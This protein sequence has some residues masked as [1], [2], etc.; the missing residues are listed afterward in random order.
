ME[1]VKDKPRPKFKYMLNSIVEVRFSDGS[2][3]QGKLYRRYVKEGENYYS[4]YPGPVRDE[5]KE[6]DI[7]SVLQEPI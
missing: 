1:I 3:F 5:C 7:L 2:G 4:F 6:S